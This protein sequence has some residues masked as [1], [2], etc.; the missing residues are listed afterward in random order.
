M[1]IYL[2]RHTTPKIEKGICYGQTDLDITTEFKKESEIILNKIPFNTKT[3]LYSSPAKR[4][5]K[6]AALI[7]K[8]YS[9]DERLKEL[10]FGNWEMKNWDRIPKEEIDPWMQDFVHIKVPNG[11]SY[12]ELAQ[13]SIAFFKEISEL[14][15][16]DV[17]VICHAGVIRSI[18]SYVTKTLLKD[19]FDIKIIYG[20]ISK[21]T[22]KDTI[23]VQIFI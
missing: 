3:K 1:E 19:S 15:N 20:Q 16:T 21:I 23:D 13:R 7:S 11:E 18:L 12:T 5:T 2:V 4:C 14:N 22:I 17:I 10:N 9:I 8:N 6:L